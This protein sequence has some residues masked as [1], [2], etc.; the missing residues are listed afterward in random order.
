MVEGKHLFNKRLP[1]RNESA[2]PHLARMISLLGPP[3]EEMLKEGTVTSELYDKN[4]MF[5]TL[6]EETLTLTYI[7]C[8]YLQVSRPSDRDVIGVRRGE[9]GSRGK[10]SVLRFPPENAAVAT[11]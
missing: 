4:G 10:G 2:G 11:C 3:P 8:R 9:F 1:S 7:A 5:P 6:R